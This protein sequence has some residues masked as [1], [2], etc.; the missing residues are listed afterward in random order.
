MKPVG[1][2]PEPGSQVPAEGGGSPRLPW[3]SP[4]PCELAEAGPAAAFLLAG[5][6]RG[7]A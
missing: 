3:R 1:G 4:Q 7:H 5:P 2:E 6:E